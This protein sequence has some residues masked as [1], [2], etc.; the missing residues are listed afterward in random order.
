MQNQYMKRR[1]AFRPALSR[2]S[3]TELVFWIN[4]N[5]RGDFP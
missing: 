3:L 1:S 2:K 5:T 4:N